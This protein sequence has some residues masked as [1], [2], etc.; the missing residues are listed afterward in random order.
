MKDSSERRARAG[1]SAIFA[2]LLFLCL[3][4]VLAGTCAMGIFSES[5]LRS[6]LQ[7]S[8]YIQE[9]VRSLR[10]ALKT[11]AEEHGLPGTFLSGQ[12][13]EN[14]FK[15]DLEAEIA[16]AGDVE[17]GKKLETQIAGSIA[18]Y[19]REHQVGKNER[20]EEASAEIAAKTAGYY[21]NYTSFPF[22]EVLFEYKEGIFSWM[23][24]LLPAS[25]LLAAVLVFLL[26][27]LH[28][29]FREGGCYG[30]SSLLATAIVSGIAGFALRFENK[31]EFSSDFPAYQA[32][33]EAFFKSPAMVLWVNGFCLALLSII[34]MAILKSPEKKERY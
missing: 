20:V 33:V 28:E 31:W 15:K 17:R 10:E 14:S 19:L 8:N 22:A 9:S 18:S 4:T 29:T 23:K 27:R 1:I 5:H 3:T 34:G 32:F 11:E 13:D 30:L 16:G 6:S 24:I 12:I 7:N 26:F 21:E 25:L 2:F